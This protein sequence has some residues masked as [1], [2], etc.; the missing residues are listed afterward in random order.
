MKKIH[1]VYFQQNLAM[2]ACEDYLYLLM[3]GINKTKFDVTFICPEASTI[4]SLVKKTEVT[5]IKVYRY[6]L[7]TGSYARIKYLVSLF[8]RLKP[9]IIHFNDPALLGFI[10]GYLAGVRRLLM[11][12]HTPELN[13]RYNL[14]GEILEKIVF[15]CIKPYVIFTSEYDRNTGIRKDKVLPQRSSVIYYGLPRARFSLTYDKKQI[16]REFLLDEGCRVVTNV[17]RLNPQKGQIYLVEAALYVIKRFKS[18]KFFFVGEGELVYNLKKE[19]KNRGLQDYFIFTGYRKDVPR[20]LS[21]S[22]MLVM[23]SLFEGLCFAVIEASAM[24]IPVIATSVGGM[25]RSVKHGETGL[26]IPPR[27]PK[28]LAEAI[29][30]ILDHPERAREMGQAAQQYFET[31]FTQERMVKKTEEFYESIGCYHNI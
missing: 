27:N 3:E 31:L 25:R 28:A 19:V 11:T 24:G 16:Y 22:E 13:R 5:G 8:R 21:I 23:P 17:A 26:L 20:L 15:R 7:N 1:I 14:K 29:I 2:G 10:A 30:W 4:E 12:H 6:S 18:V 9:D